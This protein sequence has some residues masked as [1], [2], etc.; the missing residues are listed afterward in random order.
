MRRP[1]LFITF[2]IPSVALLFLPFAGDTSPWA[3]VSGA[4]ELGGELEL[5]VAG[6][7]FFL[8]IPILLAQVRTFLKKSFTRAETMAC[9]LL[10]GAALA[11]ELTLIGA[12]LSDGFPRGEDI[13]LLLLWLI[14]FI[15]AIW[16]MVFSARRLTPEEASTIMLRA[17]WLPNAIW[18]AALFSGELRIGAYLA[19]FTA[20]LYIVEITSALRGEPRAR[21]A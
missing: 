16:V 13:L 4:K 18:C 21:E 3:A 19:A 1:I 7:P 2:A 6:A 15:A 5:A 10:A 14:L 17:A 20:V 12:L 8:T 9:R 11:A